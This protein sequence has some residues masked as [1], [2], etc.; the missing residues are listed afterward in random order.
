MSPGKGG[1]ECEVAGGRAAQAPAKSDSPRQQGRLRRDRPRERI[2]QE[3]ESR[4]LN[5]LGIAVSLGNL[6]S[7]GNS[8]DGRHYRSSTSQRLRSV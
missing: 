4:S 6:R 5:G 8:E 2:V 3:S 7:H 1:A